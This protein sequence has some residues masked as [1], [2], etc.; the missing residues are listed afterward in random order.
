LVRAETGGYELRVVAAVVDG[1]SA[2]A[3]RPDQDAKRG[4]LIWPE[5]SPDVTTPTSAEETIQASKC[6]M[7]EAQS[8]GK[9]RLR[10]T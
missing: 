7:N 4:A 8:N 2:A 3:V 1:G 6:S 9:A 10:N 5:I